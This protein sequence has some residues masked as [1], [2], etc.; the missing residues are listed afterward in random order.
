LPSRSSN[1]HEPRLLPVGRVAGH[2]GRSGE[3]TVREF[4][5]NAARWVAL[6]TVWISRR[7]G[8]TAEPVPVETAR[9][10]RDRLVL[11]LSGVEDADQAARL[12]GATVH[13]AVDDAPALPEGEHYRALLVGLAVRDETGQTLGTVRDMLGAG[14]S[15]VLVVLPDGGGDELMIPMA[16]EIVRRIDEREGWIE[17]RLPPGLR[18]LNRG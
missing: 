15:E 11:K 2:R 17:V 9:A 1:S 3:L 16:R 7:D 8:T 10:Y 5:G 6:R 14:G 12:R 13:A 18:E 4:G